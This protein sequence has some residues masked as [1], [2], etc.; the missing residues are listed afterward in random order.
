MK[1]IGNPNID[2][3]RHIIIATNVAESSITLH[4][5]KYVIDSGLELVTPYD[6]IINGERINV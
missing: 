2:K 3:T 6:E 4:N 5:I 1:T